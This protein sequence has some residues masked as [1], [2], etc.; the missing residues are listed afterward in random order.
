MSIVPTDTFTGAGEIAI[1]ATA[2]VTLITTLA[3]LVY[4][5][6]REGRRHNWEVESLRRAE[7]ERISI[8]TRVEARALE[9]ASKVEV[10]AAEVAS[11]VEVTAAALASRVE[12]AETK[13][14]LKIEENTA[15]SQRAFTEAN[16]MNTKLA[17]QGEAFDKLLATAL[18]TSG[19]ADLRMDAADKRS[20]LAVAA[21]QTTV[22]STAG[23][24]S[25]I[26]H[27]VVENGD[28]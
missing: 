2:F 16:H 1:L 6:V 19:K 28:G 26:H 27:R 22:D 3:T 24:V 4:Q 15:I 8:A 17:A 18:A 21:V 13:L 10:K 25:D 9:V 12:L 14:N 7:Q 5:F 20:S 11:R 23:Q